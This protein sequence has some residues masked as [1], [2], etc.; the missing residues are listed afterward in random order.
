MNVTPVGDFIDA[1]FVSAFYKTS[2]LKQ[3]VR[4]FDQGRR[5]MKAMDHISQN[6]EVG[7][8]DYP[9]EFRERTKMKYTNVPTSVDFEPVMDFVS[10]EELDIISSR[11]FNQMRDDEMLVDVTFD[12]NDREFVLEHLFWLIKENRNIKSISAN[13]LNGNVALSRFYAEDGDNDAY[14]AE[15]LYQLVKRLYA[16]GRYVTVILENVPNVSFTEESKDPICRLFSDDQIVSHMPGFIFEG[17]DIKEDYDPA[18]F[19]RIFDPVRL[20]NIKTL[21]IGRFDTPNP[22]LMSRIISRFNFEKLENFMIRESPYSTV[23]TSLGFLKAASSLDRFHFQYAG[24]NRNLPAFDEPAEEDMNTDEELQLLGKAMIDFLKSNNVN[25]L[26]QI[27]VETN[28]VLVKEDSFFFVTEFW[29][30]LTS[31]TIKPTHVTMRLA[32]PLVDSEELNVDLQTEKHCQNAFR[33]LVKF[34]ETDDE[35][36]VLNPGN[37]SELMN[38]PILYLDYYLDLCTAIINNPSLIHFSRSTIGDII[39]RYIYYESRAPH[40]VAPRT[41]EAKRLYAGFRRW[42]EMVAKAMDNHISNRVDLKYL[43]WK[44]IKDDPE[45]EQYIIPDKKPVKRIQ[46]AET[47]VTREQLMNEAQPKRVRRVLDFSNLPTSSSSPAPSSS[48][49]SDDY[50][51]PLVKFDDNGLVINTGLLD[52]DP[53]NNIDAS[54][55]ISDIIENYTT[56]PASEHERLHLIASRI[57]TQN[58]PLFN[59]FV[60]PKFAAAAARARVKAKKLKAGASKKLKTASTKVK[61]AKQAASKQFTKAKTNLSKLKPKKKPIPQ[62]WPAPKGNSSHPGPVPHHGP[63]PPQPHTPAGKSKKDKKQHSTPES[64]PSAGHSQSQSHHSPGHSQSQSHP[65]AGHT[66]QHP[67]HPQG[68]MKPPS[69]PAPE[70]PVKK[71]AATAVDPKNDAHMDRLSKDM[72]KSR[73]AALQRKKDKYQKRYNDVKAEKK[74]LRRQLKEKAQQQQKQVND[75]GAGGQPVPQADYT[76]LTDAQNAYNLQRTQHLTELASLKAAQ[77]AKIAELERKHAEQINMLAANRS[78]MQNN[79]L[80]LAQGPTFLPSPV[81]PLVP[82]TL[83]NATVQSPTYTTAFTL[84]PAVNMSEADP[85][86]RAQL[87]NNMRW[88]PSQTIQDAARL[89]TNEQLAD[90]KAARFRLD[91]VIKQYGTD[92]NNPNVKNAEMAF[93]KS[94][95]DISQS[96]FKDTAMYVKLLDYPEFG[97]DHEAV[98][99]FVSNV[100][101]NNAESIKLH[102]MISRNDEAGI[103]S[104][105]NK[106]Q[107]KYIR[108]KVYSRIGTKT[109]LYTADEWANRNLRKLTKYL[110][111]IKY[112]VQKYDVVGQ[113]HAYRRHFILADRGDLTVYET[114]GDI[115]HYNQIIKAI[116]RLFTAISSRSPQGCPFPLGFY[117]LLNQY[118]EAYFLYRMGHEGAGTEAKMLDSTIYTYLKAVKGDDVAEAWVDR[119]HFGN[120]LASHLYKSMQSNAGSCYYDRPEDE[121]FAL[122]LR[123]QDR[124]DYLQLT[125]RETGSVVVLADEGV[126][127]PLI[128]DIE[129]GYPLRMAI[130]VSTVLDFA[131][132]VFN[133]S[134]MYGATSITR[135]MRDKSKRF[136]EISDGMIISDGMKGLEANALWKQFDTIKDM[137]PKRLDTSKRAR[138]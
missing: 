33:A 35:L 9:F 88:F 129:I 11:A 13:F 104:F 78:Q 61:G 23:M 136:I 3:P 102:N 97:G 64:Q 135:D 108:S 76:A 41:K 53:I 48:T 50:D 51:E 132:K 114:L 47:R 134:D 32:R 126:T 103:K 127:N 128:Y 84:P 21:G 5:F 122:H 83:Q 79:S 82:M 87:L 38:I 116:W 92:L 95:R 110:A 73:N 77:D 91:G 8:D 72:D 65:S 137:I 111:P 81:V 98:R 58:D 100:A 131:K 101:S 62:P 29:K 94:V 106:R 6:Q 44:L 125:I 1:K 15:T 55:H 54:I 57:I 36:Q 124:D 85:N 43:L 60:G 66:E 69:R 138:S 56:A 27:K 52:D 14:A 93:K 26:T 2:K 7:P 120:V 67:A 34:I 40:L 133:A 107:A 4:S 115:P 70:P 105:I 75:A 68:K 59:S 31:K 113:W 63:N 42:E 18:F 45:F 96:I 25:N 74:G 123:Y 99:N 117:T 130:K 30:T 119:R 22:A 49:L 24:I 46:R 112:P 10:D 80:A 118:T 90:L 17:L 71:P 19:D 37:V 39:D 109:R 20:Q 12:I 121:G 16:N 86:V 89:M 28:A